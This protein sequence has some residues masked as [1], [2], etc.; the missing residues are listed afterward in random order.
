[1][2]IF[3]GTTT[4]VYHLVNT[5]ANTSLNDDVFELTRPSPPQTFEQPY[6]QSYGKPAHKAR[7]DWLDT[8]AVSASILCLTSAALIIDPAYP[9][10][11]RLRSGG[12]IIALGFLLGL[13][14]QCLQRILPYLFV[15]MECRYGTSMLQNYE[16]LLRWSPFTSKLGVL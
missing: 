16:G 6:S 3:A 1:M 10:A 12:Q 13:M 9:F 2:E 14:N 4:R 7:L 8:L 5:T 15:L 11:A